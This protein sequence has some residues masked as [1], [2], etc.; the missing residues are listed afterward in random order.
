MLAPTVFKL[1]LEGIIFDALDRPEKGATC[2]GVEISN[3]HFAGDIDLKS[4][5]RIGVSEEKS[6]V[7]VTGW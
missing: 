3:L 4:M 2:N 5:N 7:I 6:K 1:F